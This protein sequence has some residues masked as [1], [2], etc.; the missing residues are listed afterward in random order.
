MRRRTPQFAAVAASILACFAIA[1]CGG[2]GDVI[3]S[4]TT[5]ENIV[6][7]L[8]QQRCQ[9]KKVAVKCTDHGDDW[10]CSYTGKGGSGEVNLPKSGTGQLS[11][12]C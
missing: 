11:M 7:A 4:N 5:A 12:S 8:R 1:A 2:G 10:N 6:R 3:K 9:Q